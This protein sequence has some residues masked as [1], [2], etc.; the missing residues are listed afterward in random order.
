MTGHFDLRTPEDLR[1]KL[2]RDFDKF[3]ATPLDSDLA[4]N[5]FL[6]AEHLPDWVFPSD[7]DKRKAERSQMLL[8]IC[9]HIA[10]GAK[11]FEAT[12]QHHKSVAD[13]GVKKIGGWGGAWG[14]E[15]GGAWSGR[16][17]QL[18]I[19][20]QGEAEIQFGPLVLALGLAEKVLAY[21]N[22]HPLQ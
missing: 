8:A 10:N 21:W 18:V 22:N 14:G 7:G 4:F 13:T 17:K 15:W 3:K 19:E 12:A 11:H 5:F 2:Q 9:S 16:T 1:A 6:T 20:L